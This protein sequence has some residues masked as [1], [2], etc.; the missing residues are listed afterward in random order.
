MLHRRQKLMMIMLRAIL[1][2]SALF[3]NSAVRLLF[4]SNPPLRIACYSGRGLMRISERY[5]HPVLLV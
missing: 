2:L 1:N 5:P 4:I 3:L